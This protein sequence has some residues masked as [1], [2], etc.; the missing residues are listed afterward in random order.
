MS[1]GLTH[2]QST[3]L[4]LL[5]QRQPV[6]QIAKTVNMNRTNLHSGPIRQLAS[7]GII[8]GT[9]EL[10]PHAVWRTYPSTTSAA[11]MTA[12]VD[13]ATTRL[14]Y[15]QRVYSTL[16]RDGRATGMMARPVATGAPPWTG[17]SVR[18]VEWWDEA[19]WVV[20]GLLVPR[21][22]G[23][24]GRTPDHRAVIVADP[25]ANWA[26]VWLSERGSAGA[27]GSHASSSLMYPIRETRH[28]LPDVSK[29]N[30]VQLTLA[31]AW[32]LETRAVLDL[33]AL[34]VWSDNG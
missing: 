9:G 20:Q 31:I 32:V 24:R 16:V 29:R 15:P 21:P 33:P 28:H 11:V 5:Q 12:A 27:V 14:G 19:D 23:S 13:A 3:V 30:L 1:E 25:T 26:T 2:L 4:E 6:P 22:D 10:F 34:A 18:R 7:K 17:Q 8:R